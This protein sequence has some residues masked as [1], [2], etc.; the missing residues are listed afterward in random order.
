VE[1]NNSRNVSNIF[2]LQ[3]SRVGPSNTRME[4]AQ[5]CVRPQQ[6]LSTRLYIGITQW[7]LTTNNKSLAKIMPCYTQYY[8]TNWQLLGEYKMLQT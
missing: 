3:P 8:K 4:N 1:C 7:H 5:Y 6:H 2:K